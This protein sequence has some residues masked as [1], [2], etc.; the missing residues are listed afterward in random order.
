MMHVAAFGM[1]DN[2]ILRTRLSHHR[3]GDI[4]S[5]RSGRCRMAILRADGDA[6]VTSDFHCRKKEMCRRA[7]DNLRRIV[8]HM[9][10]QCL[11]FIQSGAKAVHFPVTG[12][13]FAAHVKPSF[14][15]LPNVLAGAT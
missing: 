14:D 1:P 8:R 4:T 13:D 9:P 2:D 3:G 11:E 5:K 12:S 6:C 7:D 10:G 15:P